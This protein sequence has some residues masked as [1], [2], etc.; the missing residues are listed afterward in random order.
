M[1]NAEA[2]QV[3]ILESALEEFASYGL[4]GAR[5]D[6]IAQQ[7][8]C[9]KNLIYMYF[10]NKE[11]LFRT[12]L[13][14]N[15]SRVYEAV[16]FTPEDLPGFAVRT[17]DFAMGNPKLMRLL[18][19]F[20]LEQK[21]GSLSVRNASL[22]TNA[23]SL[24]KAQKAGAVGTVFPPSFLITAILSLSTAWTSASPFGMALDAKAVENPK[25]LRKKIARAVG[26]LIAP[27]VA[28]E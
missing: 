25:A 1:G 9:N 11:T 21:T 22:D 18:A 2:T 3:K 7:A 20:N 14:M 28:E 8:G 16:P 10:Q 17:F 13:E 5:V 23:A 26:I 19:W 24:L 15:L 6:R 27:H 4:A 12:T